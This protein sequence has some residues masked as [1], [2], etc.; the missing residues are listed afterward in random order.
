MDESA[1]DFESIFVSAGIRGEQI[2]I[3]PNDLKVSFS[4]KFVKLIKI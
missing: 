1:L 2:Q 3:D 4:V